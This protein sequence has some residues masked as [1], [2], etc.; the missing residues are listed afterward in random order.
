MEI[1]GFHET[2]VSYWYCWQKNSLNF[3]DGQDTV[4][5]GNC[6]VLPQNLT[7]GIRTISLNSHG[8]SSAIRSM[9]VLG[10]GPTDWEKISPYIMSKAVIHRPNFQVIDM[11]G[12]TPN[13]EL[14]KNSAFRSGC[15][16]SCRPLSW[17]WLAHKTRLE[18]LSFTYPQDRLYESMTYKH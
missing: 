13:P 18:R 5:Y 10:A 15:H 4:A 7:S 11:Q 12:K 8:E 16:I 9:S 6:Q 14:V 17:Y 2:V 3:Q 1:S